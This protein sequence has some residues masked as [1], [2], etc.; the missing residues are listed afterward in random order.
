MKKTKLNIIKLNILTTTLTLI[1]ISC[2]VN[3]IDPEPKSKTNKKENIKNFVNKFQD[4]EPSKK[5]NKDLEP[6][7]EK[8]PEATASKLETTLKILEAQKEKENI[9]IAKIDNT[10]IDFLKTFK[11]DPHDSLPEDE[12][13]QMK[14]IIYSSLNYE[15]EKIKILQEILEKLDKNLQHKK[16]AKN[17]IY[18]IPIII[19]SRL[20]IISKVIKNPIKDELQ[21]LNQKEIEE[22]LMRIESELKIK[23]NFKKA[24][25]KTIDAYNQDSE[26]IKTS[27]EQLEKHI[28]ENYK[29]FNSLKPIY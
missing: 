21:I 15:T 23:E 24:L 19:Q 3:K 27:A 4:L 18:D 16:I 20:D 7:R 22:L 9:E 6:L 25:N 5:Q 26:N 10:Q 29:E 2:A 28:N 11:T 1:C 13:M 14:K 8:Y 17:F 12:K